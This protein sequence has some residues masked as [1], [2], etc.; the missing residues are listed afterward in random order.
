MTV[1]DALV[2]SRQGRSPRVAAI[3]V[4]VY[5]ALLAAVLWLD[6]AWWLMVALALPT[7]PALYEIAA[8]PSSGLRLGDDGLHWHS[9]RRHGDL[10]LTEIDRMRFDT[11][12]DLS[13]RVT[14]ILTSGKSVRLPHESL[15]AHRTF[16][17]A[18]V[19][20]GV[21]VERHHFTVF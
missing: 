6:A 5:V 2:F 15:P 7:L 20:C 18:L 4:I 3:L 14:A 13:V 11:R 8:N 21:P 10:A 12:W 16:E 17:Q 19:L 9:G 1:P